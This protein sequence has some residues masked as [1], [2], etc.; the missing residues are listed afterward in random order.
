MRMEELGHAGETVIWVP[1][2]DGSAA[3]ILDGLRRGRTAVSADL[4]T[5]L[6]L[7]CG[8]ELV[9]LDADGLALM[10]ADESRTLV[11]GDRVTFPVG[12][13][14]DGSVEVP[15]GGSTEAPLDAPPEVSVKVPAGSAG[16]DRLETWRNEVMALCG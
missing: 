4:G 5:P 13:P 7:R 2:E 8:D 12:R 6:L 16:L 10:R 15:A 1:A 3:A 9:A 11:R 14:P